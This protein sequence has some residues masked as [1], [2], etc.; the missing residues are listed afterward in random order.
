MRNRVLTLRGGPH[1]AFHHSQFPR[2]SELTWAV[3][4][5]SAWAGSAR[6]PPR[7]PRAG[8]P[9]VPPHLQHVMNMPEKP[10]ETPN[11][12]ILFL[13][14]LLNQHWTEQARPP[15]LATG[16]KKQR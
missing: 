4:S 12:V 6:C 2:A 1:S 5:A 7:Q 15:A 9:R 3:H 8:G 14:A 16:W 13:S 10:A 11:P